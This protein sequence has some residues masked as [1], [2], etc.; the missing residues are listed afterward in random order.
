MK[1]YLLF[2]GDNF[3]P[4]S[5]WLDFVNSFDTIEEAETAA[6]AIMKKEFNIPYEY[7]Y[8]Y[9]HIIDNIDGKTVVKSL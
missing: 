6:N 8:E 9:Y 3:Y 1:R 7:K 4:F 5:R 2:A